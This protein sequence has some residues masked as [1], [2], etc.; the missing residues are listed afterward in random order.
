MLRAL[1]REK[2]TYSGMLQGE[3]TSWVTF[4]R[5]QGILWTFSQPG[6]SMVTTRYG[7]NS[8]LQVSYK[9]LQHVSCMWNVFN[10]LFRTATCLV[11]H[12]VSCLQNVPQHVTQCILNIPFS[13]VKHLQHAIPTLTRSDHTV[14]WLRKRAKDALSSVKRV[15]TCH[16]SLQHAWIRRLF[17]AN[18]CF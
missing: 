3:I 18:P 16:F 5:E 12:V 4:F 1:C 11:E 17:P 15:T 2:T 8:M 7:R 9:H 6:D 10:T 14:S 13:P